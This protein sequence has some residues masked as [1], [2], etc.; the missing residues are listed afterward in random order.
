MSADNRVH[1][2]PLEITVIDLFNDSLH[3]TAKTW[4]TCFNS[5]NYFVNFFF[6]FLLLKVNIC[7]AIVELFL[8][9]LI[10]DNAKIIKCEKILSHI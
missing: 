9:K 10:K 4:S 7:L 1:E 8:K 6:F 3:S 5:I 2:E